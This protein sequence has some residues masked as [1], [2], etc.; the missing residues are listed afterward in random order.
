MVQDKDK[1]GLAFIY[2]L[3]YNKRC[4]KAVWQW[5]TYEP[6]QIRKEAALSLLVH[7]PYVH[8]K[9]KKVFDFKIKNFFCCLK[10]IK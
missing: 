6:C 4:R 10:E 5:R 1:K 8:S 2:L 7:V 9:M 3:R